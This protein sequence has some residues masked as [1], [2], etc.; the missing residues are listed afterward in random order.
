[1][2]E[3]GATPTPGWS[4]MSPLVLPVLLITTLTSCHQV[5]TWPKGVDRYIG[6]YICSS[7]FNINLVQRAGKRHDNFWDASLLLLII[8]FFYEKRKRERCEDDLLLYIL[9]IKEK[10]NS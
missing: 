2:A 4:S 8:F 5:L 10:Q 9:K 3:L 1:M 6:L 7:R